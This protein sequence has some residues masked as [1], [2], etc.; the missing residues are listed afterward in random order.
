[1]TLKRQGIHEYMEPCLAHAHNTAL[2]PV[3]LGSQLSKLQTCILSTAKHSPLLLTLS[4]FTHCPR[5]KMTWGLN[6][7]MFLP[8]SLAILHITSDIHYRSL[9]VS[10]RKTIQFTYNTGNYL[11]FCLLY[12]NCNLSLQ[13]PWKEISTRSG[14][15]NFAIVQTVLPSRYVLTASHL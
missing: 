14:I 12:K 1:M 5:F 3:A 9:D 15:F 13:C 6:N 2:H 7:K 4:T 11:M 8:W 10:T